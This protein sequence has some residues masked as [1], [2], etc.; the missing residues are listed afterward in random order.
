MVSKACRRLL[1]RWM[2]R[3]L[4]IERSIAMKIKISRHAF[5]VKKLSVILNNETAMLINCFGL[6]IWVFK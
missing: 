4:Q 5:G 3:H 1:Q 6:G 2:G